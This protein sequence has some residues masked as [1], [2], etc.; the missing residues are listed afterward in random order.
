MSINPRLI[1]VCGSA[2]LFICSN[3]FATL[4]ISPVKAKS[5]I[6]YYSKAIT[7]SA[8]VLPHTMSFGHQIA[9]KEAIQTA[10]SMPELW[11]IHIEKG[12]ANH[13]V[14]WQGGTTALSE[15]EAISQQNDLFITVNKRDHVIGAA[16]N[17]AI[18]TELSH[19]TPAIWYIDSNEPASRNIDAWLRRVGYSL[20][21]QSPT[22]FALQKT[23]PLRGPLFGQHGMLKAVLD[24]LSTPHYHLYAKINTTMKTV[25]IKGE[26][27]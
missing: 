10:L 24:D 19:K 8:N 7:P 5:K 1:S 14:S 12:L 9:L 20:K 22:D 23:V 13:S 11:R 27:R 25:T 15:L 6:I 16:S 17:E 2:C 21:W 4:D 18:A 26:S 3:A